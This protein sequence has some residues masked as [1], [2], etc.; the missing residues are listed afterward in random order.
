MDA[1]DI[2]L[3]VI[4]PLLFELYLYLYAINLDHTLSS[5]WIHEEHICFNECIHVERWL[6]LTLF[7]VYLIHEVYD[8]VAY[9]FNGMLSYLT[10]TKTLKDHGT[11]TSTQC[12]TIMETAWLLKDQNSRAYRYKRK[13][14]LKQIQIPLEKKNEY[15]Q[16]K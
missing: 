10:Q 4:L 7:T 8:V 5:E 16:F 2:N 13:I 9:Q 14:L 12:T 3:Y 6:I 15:W 11:S 1:F